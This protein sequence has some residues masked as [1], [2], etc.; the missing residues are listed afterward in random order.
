MSVPVLPIPLAALVVEQELRK[1]KKG[2]FFWQVNI[3]TRAGLIKAF[4]WDGTADA[5]TNSVFPHVGD[6]IIIHDYADQRVEHGNIIINSFQRITKDQLLP[7]DMIILDVEEAPAEDILA[8][9]ELIYDNSFWQDT[10]CHEFVMGCLSE[11]DKEKLDRCPAAQRVHHCYLGGWW[12]HTAEVL[13]LCRAYVQCAKRYNFIC[14]DVLYGGCILHDIGKYFTYSINDAGMAEQLHT[15]HTIGH[16]FYA[17][18]L[19]KSVAVNYP[20]SPKFVEEVLHCIAA[21]HGTKEWGSIVEPQSIEA[22]VLSRMDYLSS[23]NGK[24]EKV[25]KEYVQSG[26]P[27]PDTFKI[28]SDEYFSSIGIK[29]YLGAR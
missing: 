6:I 18:H 1:N 23:R 15:D 19:V 17:M 5:E 8:A 26:Q 14:A 2:G 10:S 16:M 25:L 4:K 13:E 20:V 7:Q 21:H 24:M 29:S 11:L 28:Y 3:K 12:V 22:G 27:V 9:K